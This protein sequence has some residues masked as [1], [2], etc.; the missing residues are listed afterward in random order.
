[1][2]YYNL[3]IRIGYE[4]VYE[5]VQPTPMILTLNVHSSRVSDLVYP[6]HM[7]FTPSVPVTA[8]H[9]S[10]GNWCSRIVAPQGQIK[11]TAD[12]LPPG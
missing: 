1:M 12:A 4:I 2:E 11:I 7:I 5:C 6:D 3:Q 10:Y 8:Y 9:D